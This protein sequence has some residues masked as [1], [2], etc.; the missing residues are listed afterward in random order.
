[1]R[2]S[3]RTFD[4]QLADTFTI[5]RSSQDVS[6]VAIL[7][8]NHNEVVGT[9]EACPSSYHGETAESVAR[10][11]KELA[12]WIAKRTPAEYRALLEDAAEELGDKR[13]SLSALDLAVHDWFGKRLEQPLYRIL[14]LDIGRIPKTSFT[15]GIDSI[16]TMVEKIRRIP[17][18]AFSGT[19]PVIKIKLGTAEDLEIVRALRKETDAT[20]RVDANCGWTAQET[21]EKSTEL[22]ALGVEFIEQP[23]PAEALEAMDEVYAKSALPIYADENS[24]VP[25][26]LPALK[27]RFHG[28]N[29]KLV[30]CGGIQPALKMIAIARALGLRVMIGCMVDSS[31]SASA[32]AQLGP[33]ADAL[34]LDG[35]LL[36][37][38]D[39]FK[40]LEYIKGR[41]M[42]LNRPGLGV[43][44]RE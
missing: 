12:P 25:E 43:E 35:P 20:F 5:A 4:L 26:D 1:M 15:I 6:S 23:L 42:P 24:C 8:L 38:N 40:G 30:K 41:P 16:E 18:R 7:R 31:L 28:I 13:A 14:G 10:T 37:T 29:I 11:L 36:V 2:I 27:G 34:D 22:A 21:I 17:E 44:S 9:G 19:T 3:T 39:P 33:L 32:A